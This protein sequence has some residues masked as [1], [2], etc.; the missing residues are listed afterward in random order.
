MFLC[1]VECGK[2]LY[3]S[4]SRIRV[5]HTITANKS[6]TQKTFEGSCATVQLNLFNHR[7]ELSAFSLLLN[8]LFIIR[9]CLGFER[10]KTKHHKNQMLIALCMT[11]SWTF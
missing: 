11:N 5:G 9:A 1:G 3:V 4:F 6:S 10:L 2:R 8:H 7:N